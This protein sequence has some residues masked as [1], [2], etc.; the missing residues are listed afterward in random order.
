MKTSLITS[1]SL[2]KLHNFVR[3]VK[4]NDEYSCCYTLDWSLKPSVFTR[5][6]GWI[7]GL[8]LIDA[9]RKLILDWISQRMSRL[10]SEDSVD[11]SLVIAAQSLNIR[12][13]TG[14]SVR[15]SVDWIEAHVMA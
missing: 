2:R 13:L 3:L 9:D 11:V 4:E 7:S 14:K 6:K 10:S 12:L 1:V 5:T 15:E 8:E